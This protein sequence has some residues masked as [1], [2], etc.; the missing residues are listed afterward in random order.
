MTRTGSADGLPF[1]HARVDAVEPGAE[2]VVAADREDRLGMELHALDIEL[3][4]TESHHHP[5]VALC[6]DLELVRERLAVDDEGVVAGRHERL[7]QA[8]E[9]SGVGVANQRCLAM[10][11]VGGPDDLTAVDLAHALQPEAD[12]EHGTAAGE[13]QDQVVAQPG[14]IGCAGT[15]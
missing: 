6:G 11:H 5:V 14:V 7:W 1:G 12:A 3:R 15:G 2:Q 10:H 9:H 4:V 13:V 8:G